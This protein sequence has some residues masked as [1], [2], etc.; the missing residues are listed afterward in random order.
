M[1]LAIANDASRIA[2]SYHASR[3]VLKDCGSRP[4]H[5]T[6]PYRDAWA[7]EHICGHPGVLAYTD[8]GDDK[9]QVQTFRA[10][11][12]RAEIGVLADDGIALQR[13]RRHA[14]AVNE[15]AKAGAVFHD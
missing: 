1:S 6:I 2:G 3:N 4:N 14:V 12:S 10:V 11:R 13:D 15:W 9:R 5:G 8:R 7:N